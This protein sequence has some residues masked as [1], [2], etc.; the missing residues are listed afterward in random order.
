M[1]LLPLEM[2]ER[3]S[4]TAD[5]IDFEDL[6]A[7]SVC[8]RTCSYAARRVL[9]CHCHVS[10]DAQTPLLDSFRDF[11][12]KTTSIAPI[13]NSLTVK[14]EE[15]GVDNRIRL[16]LAALWSVLQYM[17]NLRCLELQNLH[18][19]S[20]SGLVNIELAI[21]SL[22]VL[23]LTDILCE[24]SGETP[25]ALLRLSPLWTV[26]E[27]REIVARDTSD[28]PLQPQHGVSRNLV[29]EQWSFPM[30]KISVLPTP[31]PAI[32]GVDAL[33]LHHTAT[34]DFKMIQH[35]LAL[36]STVRHIELHL[37]S[38]HNQHPSDAWGFLYSEIARLPTLHS[39]TLVVPFEW[40][41]LAGLIGLLFQL[42]ELECLRLCASKLPKSLQVFTFVA[43]MEEHRAAPFLTLPEQWHH[44]LYE[45]HS[46][47]YPSNQATPLQSV[48]LYCSPALKMTH[49]GQKLK[50]NMYDTTQIYYDGMQTFG[51]PFYEVPRSIQCT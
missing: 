4:N 25:L 36:N 20:A 6:H 1:P 29:L 39:F 44:S 15:F 3:I 8:N 7:L 42:T 18:W 2:W 21:P 30:P 46:G 37:P 38:E 31:W 13:I 22:Q 17:N 27:A 11:L 12:Q 14:G 49:N 5:V 35:F 24:T 26:V 23:R 41:P 34:A 51:Y 33:Q 43:N 28:A 48:A 50:R 40:G 9:F 32:T 19:Q 16:D 47:G 10:L 45:L